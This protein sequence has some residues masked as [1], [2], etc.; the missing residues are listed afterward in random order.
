MNKSELID[1]IAEIADITKA[2]AE[3]CIRCSV[4]CDY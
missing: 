2:A 3:Q 4:R 1:D